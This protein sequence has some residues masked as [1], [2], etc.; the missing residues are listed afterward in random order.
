MCLRF[1]VDVLTRHVYIQTLCRLKTCLVY[2]VRYEQ[3]SY[4]VSCA[5][6]LCFEEV[7]KLASIFCLNT[8]FMAF[9]EQSFAGW[10]E[11]WQ[12]T[13][14]EQEREDAKKGVDILV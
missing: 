7:K 5:K 14:N 9:K 6:K 4:I 11:K 13:E 2:P 1:F 10:Q 12:N 8:H 3:S